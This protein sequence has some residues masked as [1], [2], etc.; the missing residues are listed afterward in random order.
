MTGD[1]KTRQL[2]QSWPYKNKVTRDP[3]PLGL[4]VWVIPQ[5]E[6]SRPAEV[7]DEAQ[8]M[9]NPEWMEDDKL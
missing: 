1:N 7:L 6:E 5:G 4:K 9:G 2:Q 3:D 8:Q